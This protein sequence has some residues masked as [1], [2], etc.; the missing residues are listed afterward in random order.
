M[1]FGPGLGRD[2][3]YLVVGHFG[4]TGEDVAEI[5]VGI[6]AA[7]AAGLDNAVDDRAALSGS[8]FADEEPVFLANGGGSNGVFDEV[9]VDLQSAIFQEHRQGWPLAQGIVDGLAEQALREMAMAGAKADQGAF[10][11][12]HD[13][14]AVTGAKGGAQL[15]SSALR[16]QGGFESIE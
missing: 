9:V 7:A 12:L 4:Q 14:P 16:A 15:R 6:D 8:G 2:L 1:R 11:S 10:Q 5:G 3:C 13:R